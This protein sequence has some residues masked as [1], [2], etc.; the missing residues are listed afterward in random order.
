MQHDTPDDLLQLI[1]STI[2]SVEPDAE[3]FLFGSRARGDADEQSD[4]DFLVIVPGDVDF[5]REQGIRHRLYEIEWEL[6]PVI[7]TVIVSRERWNSPL[8]QGLPFSKNVRQEG[9]PV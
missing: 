1:A 7:S 4:W 6:G 3:V 8:Y 5:K 9:I 2:R